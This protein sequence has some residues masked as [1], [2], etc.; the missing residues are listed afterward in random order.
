[1]HFQLLSV[2]VR[3]EQEKMLAAGALKKEH[4]DENGGMTYVAAQTF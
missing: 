3:I 4:R 2:I 1:M